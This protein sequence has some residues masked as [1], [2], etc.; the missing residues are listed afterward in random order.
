MSCQEGAYGF[1]WVQF[2]DSSEANEFLRIVAPRYDPDPESLYHRVL[3]DCDVNTWV[4]GTF[5]EDDN[6]ILEDGEDDNTIEEFH[7]GVPEYR[8][9]ISVWFPPS[10]LPAVMKQLAARQ[11][12][13]WSRSGEP[14]EPEEHDDADDEV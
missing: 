9:A 1:V 6:L 2:L 13:S 14:L 7:G 12:D 3:G 11:T 5:L 4:I 10:A 8:F